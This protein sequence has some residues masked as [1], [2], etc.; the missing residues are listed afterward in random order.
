[1]KRH[2]RPLVAVV[3]LLLAPLTACSVGDAGPAPAGSPAAGVP[4]TPS[5]PAAAV[6]VYFYSPQGLEPVSRPYR[7]PDPA[8]AALRQL[9]QGP[10]PAE[11]ARGLIS[12]APARPPVVM[13]R[14]EG[15]VQVFA[16]LGYWESRAAMRQL[17]CTA[18]G[19]V[20]AADGTS[21]RS[22]KVTV[23]RAT[24]AGSVTGACTP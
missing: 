8:G 20:S 19:A 12:Y 5:R 22:V 11:R 3:A 17:V 16:P 24:S 13:A 4:G 2:Y 6:H 7:G 15:S 18:A 14:G 1:M 10:D 9:A 23:H 21:L